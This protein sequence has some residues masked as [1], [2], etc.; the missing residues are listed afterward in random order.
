MALP[1]S[2][3][4][5]TVE[6]NDGRK[7]FASDVTESSW[8]YSM[9]INGS[10]I[11][12]PRSM[13]SNV[14]NEGKG[15]LPAEGTI[16]TLDAASGP[17]L[18]ISGPIPRPKN[19]PVIDP[20]ER[21]PINVSS[22]P[23]NEAQHVAVERPVYHL[24]LPRDPMVMRRLFDAVNALG[25]EN[26]DSRADAHRILTSAGDEGLAVLLERGLYHPVPS[27]RT[28]AV[29][30]LGT[31]GGK[32]VLKPLLEAFFAAAAPT[33]PPYQVSYVDALASVISNVTGQ[34]FSYYAR[35]SAR[36]PE[37]AS[38]MVQWW[39]QNWQSLPP[40]LGEPELDLRTPSNVSYVKEFRQLNLQPRQFGGLNHPL[41]MTLPRRGRDV[42]QMRTG[43]P[44]IPRNAINERDISESF[45]PGADKSPGP[46]RDYPGQWREQEMINR[47]RQR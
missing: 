8:G 39:N 43:I 5:A 1:L 13:V 38:A 9:R 34:N 4:S 26:T 47:L 11:Q 21:E 22:E 14:T 7:Y 25:F 29:R 10:L 41:G 23:A 15:E 44:T 36:G 17:P 3:W 40:Q 32:R 12:L 37:V 24:P 35:R 16:V 45:T 31:L 2:A 6:L 20:K 33:V 27:V 30:M 46:G 18:M 19:P 28:G 42:E